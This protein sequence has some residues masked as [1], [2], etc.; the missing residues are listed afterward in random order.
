MRNAHPVRAIILASAINQDGKTKMVTTLNQEAQEQLIRAC[1]KRAELD[2]S[3][4]LYFET[5]GTGTPTGDPIE[6]RT[7]ASI[8]KSTRS[9]EYPLRIGSVKTIVGHTKTTSG[10]ASIIEVPLAPGKGKI[11]R[12]ISFEKLNER[13][14]LDKR[15]LKIIGFF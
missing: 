6:A 5:H 10:L 12:N 11:P 14:H 8:F 9:R 7:V 2:L 13:I 3:Q 15:H 1:F 4:T